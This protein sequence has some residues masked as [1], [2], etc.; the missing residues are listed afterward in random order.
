MPSSVVSRESRALSSPPPDLHIVAFN[1]APLPTPTGYRLCRARV[2]GRAANP[3]QLHRTRN[4]VLHTARSPAIAGLF[5]QP[6]KS[7]RLL[8]DDL[9]WVRSVRHRHRTRRQSRGRERS[10]LYLTQ[11]AIVWIEFQRRNRAR[12]IV[13]AV[14]VNAQCGL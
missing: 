11:S 1:Y 14:Q 7:Y 10:V 5:V 12:K 13:G 4:L 6:G 2:N 9:A 8:D 3:G